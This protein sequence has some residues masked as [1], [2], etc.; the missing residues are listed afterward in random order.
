MHTS[1]FLQKRAEPTSRRTAYGAWVEE[2]DASSP[3]FFL[4][5]SLKRDGMKLWS[6]RLIP[7]LGQPVQLRLLVENERRV[8]EIEGRIVGHERQCD[9]KRR[10]SVRFTNLDGD[11]RKF[12][13]QLVVESDAPTAAA[14][15]A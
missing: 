10:F 4:A 14:A 1:R 11:D 5:H 12:V 6:D 9:G 2:H 8:V 7:R 3:S 15:A 13:E